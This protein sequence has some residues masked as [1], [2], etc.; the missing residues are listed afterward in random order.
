MERV[1]ISISL[2]RKT[3]R[4]K[5]S[6]S[7]ETRTKTQVNRVLQSQK[8]HMICLK[9]ILKSI[10]LSRQKL[11]QR[12][13]RLKLITTIFLAVVTSTKELRSKTPFLY[14]KTK[15]SMCRAQEGQWSAKWREVTRKS[16]KVS[17][18]KILT[19]QKRSIQEKCKDAMPNLHP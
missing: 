5:K 3:K 12:G 19:S 7:S 10:C 9:D 4:F 1:T 14:I 6:T 17:N 13:F 11:T 18:F 8:K 2:R 15:S 16:T